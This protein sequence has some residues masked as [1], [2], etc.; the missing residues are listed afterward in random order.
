LKLTNIRNR[1]AGTL[2]FLLATVV[3]VCSIES[4]NAQ[5]AYAQHNLVSDVAG[6]ANSTDTNLVNPWGIA[7]SPTGPF[8]ISDNH[9][10]LSTV[11]DSAGTPQTL[12]VSIPTAAGGTP[13][14]APTGI[15]FNNTTNFIVETN[16]AAFIFAGEDGTISAWS[17]G[18]NAVLKA[19][20]STSET[21]YKGLALASSGGSNY[22]YATDFHN[23]KIDVFDANFR[24]VTLAGSFLDPGIPV[25]YAPFG[26][27]SFGTNLFVTYAKQDANK[28]DDVSGLGN[29]FVDVFDTSG[30]LVK[31]FASNGQLNSPWGMAMAP[32][33]F[34]E[35]GG[36]LLIGNFGDGRINAFDPVN[37]V[38]LGT[39]ATTNGVPVSIE[40]LWGV[41]FG[42]GGKGGNVNTLYFT[43]GISGGG[44]IE[45]HGLFGSIEVTLPIQIDSIAATAS[46]LTLTWTGGTGPYLV[47][48][49]PSLSQ[50]NWVNVVTTTNQTATVAKDGVTGFFRISD[51]ATIP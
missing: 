4:A 37:G 38:F 28:E 49:K 41:K 11:Y 32:A 45:D 48:N 20:N 44:A 46:N 51:H 3:A 36:D 21:I 8:W 26:I 19:D 50:T 25:G 22:L 47:Q 29:G 18:T 42:N 35:F 9:S 7:F 39:L 34:G 43:A 15:V 12:I 2:T 5:S 14:G 24:Q 13:P 40:G 10:G 27:E 30:N 6:L 16:K 17:S 23:G 33:T 31:R 1:S